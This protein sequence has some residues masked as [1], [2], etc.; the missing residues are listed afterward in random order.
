MRI[1][2][3]KHKGRRIQAP[4]N[5]PV[6][7]TTDLS[8]ESLFNI[9]NNHFNFSDLKV[10]DLFCGTGNISF[11]FSSR[12]VFEIVA[13]DK[14]PACVTFVYK[15]A[16]LL[17]MNIQTVKADVFSFLE[18]HKDTYDL[19]FADPPYDL[20]SEQFESI[21]ELVFKNKLLDLEGML[22]VEHSK[23][24]PMNQLPYFSFEKN[25]GNSVFSFFEYPDEE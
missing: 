4:K 10:L 20:K 19:V 14:H 23:Q 9:L 15:T 8:K 22:V 1:I 24:T 25:Y 3:G 17:E 18:K 2:S 6:R 11:E 5:L 12:G 21:V 7:P 16:T 13:V